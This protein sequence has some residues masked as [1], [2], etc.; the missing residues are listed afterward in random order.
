MRSITKEEFA[1]SKI[2]QPQVVMTVEWELYQN[3]EELAKFMDDKIV[4]TFAQ[5]LKEHIVYCREIWYRKKGEIDYELLQDVPKT[6]DKETEEIAI[7]YFARIDLFNFMAAK[8]EVLERKVLELSPRGFLVPL[9]QEEQV[10][11]MARAAY[12]MPVEVGTGKS[13]D[14]WVQHYTEKPEEVSVEHFLIRHDDFGIVLSKGGHL[15]QY[16]HDISE[17]VC[18]IN[19]GG[20]DAEE[21]GNQFA[22]A[23]KAFPEDSRPTNL[24]VMLSMGWKVV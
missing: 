22:A 24:D 6:L 2:S 5:A 18:P 20:A 1:I 15:A 7:Q 21:F 3:K 9:T 14:E 4:N 8:I 17:G 10:L 23:S 11:I 12:N 13:F 19:F 16:Y